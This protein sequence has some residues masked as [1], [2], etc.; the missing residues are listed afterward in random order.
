MA[1]ILPRQEPA[2]APA[3]AV[4]CAVGNAVV[5]SG[6]GERAAP[7]PRKFRD[8]SV[9]SSEHGCH[10]SQGQL[11]PIEWSW[12]ISLLL[13]SYHLSSAYILPCRAISKKE[14][15]LRGHQWARKNG[16]RWSERSESWKSTNCRGSSG[17]KKLGQLASPNKCIC[18]TS[19]AFAIMKENTC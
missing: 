14:R 13:D 11:V 1:I 10:E 4:G 2:W 16:K 3:L 15:Q 17:L 7:N 8:C 18:R 19:S 6:P 9:A 12:T 5:W